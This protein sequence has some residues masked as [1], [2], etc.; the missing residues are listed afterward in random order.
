MGVV[1]VRP[2]GSSAAFPT[3]QTHIRAKR[4]QVKG[5][6]ADSARRM[7]QWLW[8][9]Q[10]DELT[11]QGFALTLTVGTTPDDSDAWS[12]ARET[13]TDWVRDQP[14]YERHQWL[15]E[16]TRLGRPHLH[17]CVYADIEP[18][19]AALHWMRIAA[20]SGWEAGWKGQHVEAIFDDTG[21]LKYVAKHSARGVDHYQRD[22]P[23]E[24]WVKTGRLWG[25]GGQWPTVEEEHF[26]LTAAQT[27][28]YMGLFKSWQVARMREERV[29]EEV[30]H[31]YEARPLVPPNGGAPRGLSGWIPYEESVKL[32]MQITE[33]PDGS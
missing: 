3:K 18:A 7:I 25:K 32:L 27:W 28:Q 24:G 1:T 20:R 29:S 33:Y 19:D 9:V 12:A 14:G 31:A 11:G 2:G 13:F 16:W 6:T 23:P 30:I 10:A 22:T 15:T 5:W 21:W 17:L 26:Y 4:G 8:S